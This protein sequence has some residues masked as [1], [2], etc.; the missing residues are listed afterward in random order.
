MKLVIEDE[1]GAYLGV[2]QAFLKEFVQNKTNPNFEVFDSKDGKRRF[3]AVKSSRLPDDED[4]SQDK[5]GIDFHRARPDYPEATQYRRGLPDALQTTQRINNIAFAAA[6]KEEYDGK[7]TTWEYFY[8]YIWGKKPQVVWVTPHSGSV[9]RLPDNILPFPKWET[10]NFASEVTAKCAFNNEDKTSSRIMLSIHSHNWYGAIV[11]LGGFGVIDHQQ[12]AEA[13]KKLELKYGEKIQ[14]LADGCK[15]DF[16]DRATRWL[17][18]IKN[19]NGSLNPQEIRD[20][21]FIDSS[22]LNNIIKALKIYNIEIKEYSFEE[23]QEAILS[24]SRKKIKAASDGRIFSALNAGKNLKL[25][26]KIDQG[27][28][29]SA[30]QIECLKWYAAKAPELVS[31]IILDAKYILIDK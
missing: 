3:I 10:D 25:T 27:L 7:S 6:S 29:N 2:T 16:H 12:L 22:V 20:T 14:T 9:S 11:D 17:E 26:E 1:Y 28:I 31:E 19:K 23:Y 8:S 30:L 18:H 4:L 5:Y 21:A 24:L 15:K 13:V